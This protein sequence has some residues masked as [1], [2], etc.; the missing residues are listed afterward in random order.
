MS[1]VRIIDFKPHTN[2]SG[3][4]VGFV[5]AEFASGLVLLGIVVL[6]GKNGLYALPPGRPQLDATGRARRKPNGKVDYAPVIKFRS[7]D[8][9]DKWSQQIIE[10][11]RQTHASMLG[12]DAS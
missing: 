5:D 8:I 1:D 10:A 9:N 4:L 7:K 2:G 11:L 6:Q 12:G 3:P